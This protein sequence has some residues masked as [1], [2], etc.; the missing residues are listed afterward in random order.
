VKFHK[1]SS[2]TGAPRAHTYAYNMYVCNVYTLVAVCIRV[3]A[4]SVAK[5]QRMLGTYCSLCSVCTLLSASI[6]HPGI[7]V[8]NFKCN[9]FNGT[10]LENMKDTAE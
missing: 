2:A 4:V 7:N 5:T 9:F 6:V 8:Q 3:L 10:V 1:W